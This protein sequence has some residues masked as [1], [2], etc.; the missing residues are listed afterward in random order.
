MN[1]A[2]RRVL[3]LL[4]AFW[5]AGS[6]FATT[7]AP[8]GYQQP[9]RSIVALADVPPAPEM[10]VDE[11]AATLVIL[12]RGAFV[13]MAE[14]AAPTISLGGIQVDPRTYVATTITLSDNHPIRLDY[15]RRLTLQRRG[16]P[17][18]IVVSGLPPNPRLAY[19]AWSPDQRQLA[20]TYTADDGMQ[21]WVLELDSGRARRLASAP[22]N[23]ALGNPLRWF[24][25]GSA[26]LA[27][28]VPVPAPAL[29]DSANA[30]PDG[31]VVR[32]SGDR[33][34]A[35]R[36]FPNLLA[37]AV[38]D[39]NF[40]A[41]TTAALTWL[42]LHG[43]PQ[44]FAPAAMYR[45]MQ[46]SPDGNW[47]LVETLEPPFSHR[48][49]LDR[50]ATR[51][52]LL[53]RNG[54][55]ALTVAQTPTSDA[56]PPGRDAAPP[57]KRAFGWRAD[58]PATLSWVEALDG[59]DPARQVPHRDVLQILAAPFDAAPRP[60]V[61]TVNRLRQVWWGDGDHA[62]AIDG[63]WDTRDTRTYAFAPDHPAA[64]QEIF[65]RNLQDREADPG[66]F[67]IRRN[68][69]GEPVLRLDGRNAWLLG[70]GYGAHGRRPF[71]DRVDLSNGK[72]KRVFQSTLQGRS[73]TLLAM[74][75]ARS[76]HVLASIES[77]AE[78]PNHV[79]RDLDDVGAAPQPLTHFGAPYPTLQGVR[80]QILHYRR[81]DGLP[82]SAALYLPA[83]YQTNQGPLPLGNPPGK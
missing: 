80:R 45:D 28:T 70:E 10:M 43:P 78:Y 40:T 82:L 65:R 14:L 19:F 37:N 7:P 38:D 25:D 79:L 75:G 18:P 2:V 21:A 44:A 22:L 26:L 59:G 36:T 29:V 46:F 16:Q 12:Q 34:A 1:V 63:W 20:F 67:A 8:S 33:P 68:A 64:A 49:P 5:L 61:R 32:D 17:T 41:L 13:P 57:G 11:A 66:R 69:S 62:V 9:A 81:A 71:V 56:L 31:P 55:S 15:V 50:F 52:A 47:L 4:A 77:P 51:H 42:A 3:L 27:R 35:N 58:A 76:R 73:E 83:G 53:D 39:A 30:L 48:A 60:L 6:S 24:R 72:R 54:E 74:V 23:A